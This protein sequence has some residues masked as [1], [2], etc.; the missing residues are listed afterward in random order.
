MTNPETLTGRPAKLHGGA[1]GA[2]L[3]SADV[4]PGDSA[5]LTTKAGKT[6]DVVVDRVM[7]TG[8]D[9]EGH[10]CALVSLVGQLPPSDKPADPSPSPASTSA[11]TD[12]GATF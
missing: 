5:V 6:W 12:A 3:T 8:L 10:P 2:H 9:S 4:K 7:W 1:W 11:S